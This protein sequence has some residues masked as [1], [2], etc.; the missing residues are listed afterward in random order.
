[1]WLKR[2]LAMKINRKLCATTIRTVLIRIRLT[3]KC[4]RRIMYGV[5]FKGKTT[6]ILIKYVRKLIK[7]INNE[8]NQ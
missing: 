7:E 4:Y 5:L 6:T 1:M 2:N 8:Q 3:L